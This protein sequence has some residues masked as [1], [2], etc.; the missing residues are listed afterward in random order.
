M[1][2]VPNNKPWSLVGEG[3]DAYVSCPVPDGW[4]S[5]IVQGVQ[6]AIPPVGYVR[7]PFGDGLVFL[8]VEKKNPEPD[9]FYWV[10]TG[11]PSDYE[12]KIA[13][14]KAKQVEDPGYSDPY[15]EAFRQGAWVRRLS[16][17][18]FAN[19][20]TGEPTY[21]T[22]LHY[23]Y[24]EWCFIAA[25][26]NRGYPTF[27]ESDRQFFLFTEHCLRNPNCFGV[28]KLTKR[29]DGKTAKSVAFGLEPVMRA[30]FSNLGIQSKTAE[31]AAKVVFKD[32]IIRTF[33]RLPDFFK[34][35]HDERRLNNINNTLIFK[36][37][38]VDT[39][40]FRRNDYLGGWIEHRSSSETAF[41]GT[42]LL[43][44]IGDEVF[45]TQVG[46]DVYERWNIVKFCLIIDGKIKGKAM[47]TSTVE[48][49]EGSTDMYVKMYA[50]SDQL[51]LDDGTRRTK[52]GL[53]RFFLPADEA[54]NRDKYGKCDKSANRDEIIA[55]RKAY[56]DDAMSYNSLVRKE[57]L[58]VEE[59]FRF[60]SRESVFDTIKISD[61]IDLVAWRQEQ[62]V[63]RGNYVW[64]T[65]GSEVKW[66]PTQKGRWLRVKDYPHPVNPLSEADNTSYKVDYRP[67]GTDM[68]V[69]GID[70]FSHSRVE[71][72]QKS[73]AAFYVKRKHDPLQ[74]DIS[75]MFVLQYIYRTSEVEQFYEDV[76]ITLFLYGC[77]GLIENNKIGMVGY[78]ENERVQNF[79]MKVK[80]NKNYGIAASKRT[81]QAMCEM[82]EKY[83][84]DNI[85]KVFFLELLKDWANFDI[86][87]TQEFDAAMASGYTLLAD[88]KILLRKQADKPIRI[89]EIGDLL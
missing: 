12:Q 43:R 81:T 86:D 13:E 31:D 2:T 59:A 83:I 69:C 23:F 3:K 21:I 34:P 30:G 46:V 64:K 75:D 33:A 22:G 49:I 36:P 67:M 44:Y 51:K 38:Q 8:G 62:L 60:L 16:G 42:K 79:L 32:G 50:D 76:F 45:K 6:S 57:P 55:E 63:E 52:T 48:E 20:P 28:L 72:R 66:V 70:P 77:Q 82:I 88:S 17:C 68:Y 56:A 71:G 14:E 54:R 18:W 65:Y 58:T 84:Y 11:L 47:L 40:A 7:D 5:E 53:F 27:R 80:G 9:D 29:R 24:L 85:H 35:N 41:D 1:T 37:K 26:G 61:Q 73:D 39:E 25:H 4:S 19:G 89:L 15:I 78:F 74:P 10:R 87:D